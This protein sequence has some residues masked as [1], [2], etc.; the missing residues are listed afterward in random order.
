MANFFR[1][2]NAR[3]VFIP[4]LLLVTA[5]SVAT[6]FWLIYQNNIFVGGPYTTMLVLSGFGLVLSAFAI[7]YNA[8]FLQ[9]ARMQTFGLLCGLALF[10][11]SLYY[12]YLGVWQIT[13]S[14]SIDKTLISFFYVGT[15][16]ILLTAL[17][18]FYRLFRFVI[19]L[20]IVLLLSSLLTSRVLINT[21]IVSSLPW[22]A[23]FNDVGFWNLISIVILTLSSIIAFLSS[24][25]LLEKM[26]KTE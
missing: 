19:I 5:V 22:L 4:A 20:V 17:S 2:Y 8:C 9:F 1:E 25:L 18:Q 6:L 21:D 12:I 24:N 23:R 26:K 3:S 7:A 15:A 16:L 10:G 14:P 11:I 13:N